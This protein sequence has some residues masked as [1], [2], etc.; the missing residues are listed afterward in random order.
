MNCMRVIHE[1]L[2]HM[3]DYITTRY[4]YVLSET[5]SIC[6]YYINPYK[7]SGHCI[8]RTRQQCNA[9]NIAALVPNS[10][11]DVEPRYHH[12]H[13][14]WRGTAHH[15][16]NET[17]AWSC[18]PPNRKKWW[19]AGP[20]HRTHVIGDEFFWA[21]HLYRLSVTIFLFLLPVTLRL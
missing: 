9:Q 11:A 13:V 15:Q 3:C 6:G 18:T 14:P 4:I 1:R 17:V 8:T 7:Y 20:R 10:G 21:R 12:G 19:R 5:I 2:L 16:I